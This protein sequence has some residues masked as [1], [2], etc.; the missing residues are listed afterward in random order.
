MLGIVGIIIDRCHCAELIKAFYKHALMVHIGETHG[1]YYRCHASLTAPLLDSL[2]Q[3]IDNLGV[4][5]KIHKSEAHQLLAGLLIIGL[6]DDGCDRSYRLSIAEGHKRLGIAKI[7]SRIHIGRQC[8]HLIENQR[9][10]IAIIS[11][12]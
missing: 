6:I 9:R 2:E 4:I 11:F 5:Y 7:K 10:N 1:S 8:P 12:I 3:F